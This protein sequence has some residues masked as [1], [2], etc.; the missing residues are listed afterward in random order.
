MI[1][2]GDAMKEQTKVPA[3]DPTKEPAKKE[4]DWVPA[5]EG[6]HEIYGNY[7]GSNWG[8][9]DVRIRV[10]QLIPRP[11]SRIEDK[12][13]IAQE[14]AGL[15]VAWPEAKILAR[16]LVDLVASYERTNG[17]IKPLQLPPNPPHEN[18]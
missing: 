15:T 12:D 18:G 7:I 9:F 8:I 3:S 1:K 17:E 13:M 2:Q 11:G 4:P 5:P 6:I 16:M 14:R 10:G